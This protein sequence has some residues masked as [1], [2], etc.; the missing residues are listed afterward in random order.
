MV[1]N[2]LCAFWS[3]YQELHLKVCESPRTWGVHMY[4]YFVLH[5]FGSVKVREML[6]VTNQVLSQVGDKF[7]H[8]YN[9][10]LFY[11]IESGHT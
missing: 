7:E 4:R 11:I 8:L 9:E 5:S 10:L 3:L 1:R 2:S 6:M